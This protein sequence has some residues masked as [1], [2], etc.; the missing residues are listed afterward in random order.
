MLPFRLE[1]ARRE[2][3]VN[4]DFTL[5]AL[6]VLRTAE[7][8]RRGEKNDYFCI[9][10]KHFTTAWVS[11]SQNISRVFQFFYSLHIFLSARLASASA[12]ISPFFRPSVRD[13][14]QIYYMI[15]NLWRHLILEEFQQKSNIRIPW[16]SILEE[17]SGHLIF[18]SEYWSKIQQSPNLISI[19]AILLEFHK[20]S[21]N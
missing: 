10:R 16:S 5:E 4:G 15:N 3:E 11:I 8:N 18:W 9:G 21:K 19:L 13:K 20:N 1:D 7:D 14:P 6:N 12:S 17:F 2:L